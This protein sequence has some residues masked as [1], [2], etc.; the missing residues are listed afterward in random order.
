[1]RG[2]VLIAVSLAVVTALG[3]ALCASLGW[4]LQSREMIVAMVGCGAAGL[5]G[6]IPIRL[7]R[8]SDAAAKVQAGLAA[9]VAHLIM[10]CVMLA[11]VFLGKLPMRNGFVAWAFAFYLA[12]LVAIV[13]TFNHSL[14]GLQS[15]PKTP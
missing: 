12:T 7:A 6:L 3:T 11:V 8:N 2:I 9:S 10:C 1:M 13:L 15:Q 5:A 4:T 14:R